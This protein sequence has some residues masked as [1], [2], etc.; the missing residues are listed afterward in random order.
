MGHNDHETG[1]RIELECDSCGEL[2]LEA[3]TMRCWRCLDDKTVCFA[4]IEKDDERRFR[5]EDAVWFCAMCSEE[6]GD[7]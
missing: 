2:D 4:C 1:P 3:A 6:M 7:D 5:S